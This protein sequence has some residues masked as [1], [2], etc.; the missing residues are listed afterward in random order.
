MCCFIARV[1]VGDPPRVIG[2]GQQASHGIK[3][4]TVVDMAGAELAI[5][6]AVHAAEH[7]AGETID[8][9]IVNLAGGH[10]ASSSVSV[11]IA[12]NGHEVGEADLR[13][14]FDHCQQTYDLSKPNGEHRKAPGQASNGRQLIHSIPTAYTI[15]G[16]RGVRDPRGMCG[17]RLGVNIHFVTAATSAVRNLTTCIRRCHL[18]VAG[19]VV[20]SFASGLA[21]LAD[22]ELE[23]GVTVIDMG[24]GITSIA[25]FY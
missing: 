12:L 5:L 9:V 8:R 18:D 6:N 11:Q 14:A 23:L 20:S 17:D 15:D 10:P 22:D 1:E 3:N 21:S 4:G 25:V 7:M 16:N 19:Y 2:I 13:R 24:G